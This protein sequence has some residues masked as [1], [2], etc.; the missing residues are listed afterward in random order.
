MRAAARRVIAMGIGI[1][2]AALSMPRVHTV[3]A[4]A[5]EAREQPSDA[6][7]DRTDA[8]QF[9]I[10]PPPALAAPQLAIE[11]HTGLTLPLGNGGLC[12]ARAGCVLQAGGGVGVS[13]ER[14]QP[15]G[16]GA[17]IAYDVWFLDSDSV[18]ELAVQQQLR[19]GMRYTAPTEFVFHP[20]FELS[21]GAM[22]FGDIFRA[23]TYGVVL[24]GFSGIETELTETFG[25]RLGIGLR[26]FS[27]SSFRSERDG[28]RRGARDQFSE[29][30][31]IEA[32]LTLM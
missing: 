19:G 20:I 31:F 22:V 30:F 9:D 11:V 28:V 1:S 32:G 6:R 26:G 29:A 4:Q 13:L 27:H 24:Q 7:D 8:I 17:L 3:H 15:S 12:P 21:L 10:P 23:A 18:Y 16:F 25:V 2:V 5:V 14:R